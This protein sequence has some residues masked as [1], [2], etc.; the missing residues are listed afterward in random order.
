[1]NNKIWMHL[2]KNLNLYV[3]FYF[4]SIFLNISAKI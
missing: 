3:M 4:F 2:K 1:M